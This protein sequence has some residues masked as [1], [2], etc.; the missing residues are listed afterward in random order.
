MEAIH[1]GTTSRPNPFVSDLALAHSAYFAYRDGALVRVHEPD[2]APLPLA[3]FVHDSFRALV[4]NPKFACV[5]AKSAINH[6]AYRMGV[7]PDLASPAATAG[8]AHD[9]YCFVQEQP[10]LGD[11][12]ST[13][14][15]GFTGPTAS[16]ERDFE[17]LLWAQLQAL[18]DLDHPHHA[19]DES[20]S[21]DPNHGDFSFSFGGRAFFVVGL[22]AAS[23]RWTRRFAWP[24]LVFNAH[25]QF[26][27]L[28]SAGKYDRMQQVIRNRDQA[29]QGSI[30]ANLSDFGDRSEARQYSGRPVEEQWICPFHAHSRERAA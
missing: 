30:N 6:G 5:A 1:L 22:H 3:E 12:F 10:L 4:L 9:L 18:H 14:V 25:A 13:F 20:V 2:Q 21:S 29:L 11:G 27:T 28:R 7:Y 26:E 24:T 16:D 15:A 23:S 8:L 17:R 19:W